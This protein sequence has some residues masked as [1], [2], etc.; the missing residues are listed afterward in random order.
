MSNF[1]RKE[2]ELPRDIIEFF[3]YVHEMIQMEDDCAMIESDDLLQA[4]NIFGGL[5]DP[6]HKVYEF[7]WLP[8]SDPQERWEVS[9][10]ADEIDEIGSGYRPKLRVK[11]YQR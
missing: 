3:A 1:V 11:A 5:R 10:L 7:V 2:V 4:E 9:L 8:D 6:R